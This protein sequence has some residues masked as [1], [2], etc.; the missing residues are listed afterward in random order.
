[1]FN[2][3]TLCPPQYLCSDPNFQLPAQFIHL[4]VKY[5]SYMLQV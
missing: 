2:Y 4:H 3:Q 5:V 1:M